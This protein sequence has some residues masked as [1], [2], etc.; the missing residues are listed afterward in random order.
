M[1]AKIQY[2][3]EG[4]FK[5]DLFSGGKQMS[6]TDWFNNFITHTGLSYPSIYPFV[7]CF[8]YLSVG[9]S[10]G[11]NVANS[12]FIAG[13]GAYAT[14]GLA[15]PVASY[16]TNNGAQRGTH[17]GWE[18]YEVGTDGQESPCGTILTEQGPAFFRA[19]S[20]PTGSP[21]TVMNEPGG[22]LQIGEFMVS[23][24]SGTDPSGRWAFS[25]ITRNLSIPNGWRA[26]VSYQLKLKL[27][28]TG[29]SPLAS[30]SFTTGN[31]DITNDIELVRSW[32]TLSGFYRQVYHGLMCI[33]K[34]G[35]SYVPRYGNIMEPCLTDLKSAAFYLSP[36]NA[37]FDVNG[38]YGGAQTSE[39]AAYTADGLMSALH[40]HGIP[41]TWDGPDNFETMTFAEKE[42][43]YYAPMADTTKIQPDFPSSSTY[44]T[45]INIRL[46]YSSQPLKTPSL[47]R[48]SVDNAGDLGAS[49]NYQ[50]FQDS[51]VKEISYATR[52]QSGED[53][54]K[55]SFGEK[56]VFAARVSRL[57]MTNVTGRKK[58]LTRRTLFAP[59]SSLGT[60]TRFGSL[61]CAYRATD[62]TQN[63]PDKLFYPMV[64]CLFFDSRN[65][66]LMQHYRQI[67][68]IYMYERGTG[69]ADAYIG[70]IPTGENT[71]RFNY[72]RTIQG[73]VTG[74]TLESNQ[75][76]VDNFDN[77][78][79]GD[80]SRNRS[81]DINYKVANAGYG[82]GGVLG[83]TGEDYKTLPYDL[84]LIDHNIVYQGGFYTVTPMGSTG[85]GNTDPIYWP[86]VNGGRQLTLS[87]T[88][89][90]FYS[91]GNIYVDNPAASD[92]VVRGSGFCR[93]TGYIVHYENIGQTGYRLLPNHGYPNNSGINTYQPTT[94]GYYPG[95]S[96]DNGL[97]LYLDITWNSDCGNAVN[98]I[99]VA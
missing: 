33:D 65:R 29:R 51:S 76:F 97:D 56:A 32:N 48:Y 50:A 9:Y 88:G 69:V 59:V 54:T 55:T 25:R 71:L 96:L 81:G 95:L 89:I 3:L 15:T 8:R 38:K 4:S 22:S 99:N 63:Y 13:S 19:W 10:A 44:P 27:Q 6:S 94:G 57:P 58:T 64:D 60:N 11:Y 70:I 61:V 91:G 35:N 78:L 30:G 66:A 36:D 16:Q 72:R 80:N 2:G 75:F 73:L 45:P 18:G 67:S 12:G 82:R 31:A 14:T 84:G 43:Y 37:A 74:G 1:K 34:R 42:T 40:V 49:F 28:N 17:I 98:C 68:G 86:S 47:T 5:V 41:M 87:I 53:V 52:G 83:V 26:I 79:E 90:R 62:A 39:V 92:A 24:S 7:D 93:P 85:V 77:Y 23:P 21:D 46:G 20:I